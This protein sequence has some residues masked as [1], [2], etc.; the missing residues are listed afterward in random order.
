[1]NVLHII[2]NLDKVNFGIWNAALLGQKKLREEY[3]IHS[4]VWCCAPISQDPGLDVPVRVLSLQE[5]TT[6]IF[7][8]LITREFD[9]G[10]TI[11]VSHGSWLLPSKLGFF[12]AKAGFHWIYTPHGML[13]PWSLANGYLKKK[14]YYLL[15]ERKFIRMASAIRAV[16]N[17]EYINLTAKLKGPVHLIPNG[18]DPAIHEEKEVT[19]TV[20]LFMARLHH[21]KGILPL[22]QAWTAAVGDNDNM[23]LI[24]AGPD[25]GELVKIRPY[26]KK[27]IRYIGAIYKEEKIAY[28]QRANYF[29]LPSFSEGFATSVLEAMSYGSIPLISEGCN[30]PEAF[31]AGLA[32]I[33]K[34]DFAQLA[35]KL[36]EISKRQPDTAKSERAIKFI[37]HN[38][39]TC[40]LVPKM[41]DYYNSFF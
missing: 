40:V 35:A 25:D 13:E 7:T 38:Y 10:T 14:A 22:V 37:A 32:E 15:A 8:D 16:S 30:F 29:V 41:A 31:D 3:G 2:A 9:P 19:P 28:L 39:S 4:V 33:A 17:P 26:L 5:M 21:K 34:P 12:A 36:K 27:N 1:M 11:V 20:F 24:I 6:S 18:V 23:Q